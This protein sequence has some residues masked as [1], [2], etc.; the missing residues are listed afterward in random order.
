MLRLI[1]EDLRQ[2]TEP[3]E[4]KDGLLQWARD[5]LSTQYEHL[6]R[7]VSEQ[8]DHALERLDAQVKQRVEAAETALEAARLEAEEAGRD[9][10]PNQLLRLAEES[11]GMRIQVDPAGLEQIRSDP[12]RFEKMIPDLVEAGLGLRIWA[13]LLQSVE[14]RLGE[15]LGLEPSLQTPVDWD[16]ASGKLRDAM[17]RLWDQRTS[18]VLG[19]IDR[20]LGQAL[21]DHGPVADWLKTRLLVQMSYGQRTFF[22]RRTHQKR[23]FAVARLSYPF[24]AARLL[25]AARKEELTGQVL[26]HLDGAL[27][28]IQRSLGASELSRLAVPFREVDPAIQHGLTDSLDEEAAKV[29]TSAEALNAVRGEARLALEAALGRMALSGGLRGLI[30]AVGDR[31]WVEYLTQMEAL[32]TSIGLEAYGQR[33]PL[34]Q[35]KS[36][37]FDMFQQLMADIRAGVA[38]RVFRAQVPA[39]PAPTLRETEDEPAVDLPAREE[40]EPVAPG[41]DTRRK[42]RRR[43]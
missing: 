26:D 28:E 2:A 6:G 33:D 39:Q 27:R 29:M 37:A 41:E 15:P 42:H 11:T 43:H 25:E 17:Q 22:D 21:P 9:I 16:A 7:V 1:L 34:V 31:Q 23:T 35:Y 10:D 24:A 30:L 3:A 4:V 14:R 18:N 13:G 36:R 20:E 19:E 8:L 5:A 12:Q 32:R 38:S 40:H